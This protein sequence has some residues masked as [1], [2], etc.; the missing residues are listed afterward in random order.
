MDL[1]PKTLRYMNADVYTER[2][3]ESERERDVKQR[4]LE[5]HDYDNI[6]TNQELLYTSCV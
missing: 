1:K 3:G 6:S 4:D 2:H 5:V